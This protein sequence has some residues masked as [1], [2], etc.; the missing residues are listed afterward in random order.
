MACVAPG[1]AV[2][3]LGPGKQA[4]RRVLVPLPKRSS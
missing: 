3:E 4:D 1:R 2:R